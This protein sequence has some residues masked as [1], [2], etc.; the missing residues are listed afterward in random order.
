MKT[1]LDPRFVRL[2]DVEEAPTSAP[3]GLSF[4]RADFER[5]GNTASR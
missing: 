2:N 3:A 4:Y 5:R 1:A